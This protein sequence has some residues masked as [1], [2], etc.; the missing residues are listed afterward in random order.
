MSIE[1][2]ASTDGRNTAST[3]SMNCIESRVSNA[4]MLP[5][6]AVSKALHIVQHTTQQHHHVQYLEYISIAGTKENR[7]KTANNT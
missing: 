2:I 3:P 7:V 5:V 1:N 4:E 6:Q